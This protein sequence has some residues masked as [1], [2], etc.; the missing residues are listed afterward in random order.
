MS[1][2]LRQSRTGRRAVP[3]VVPNESAPAESTAP[4]APTRGRP[5]TGTVETVPLQDGSVSIRARFSHKGERY[6]VVFGRDVEGWT[7]Q[8]GH[9]ELKNIYAQLD[10]GIPVE[11]ILARY[12]PAP[13]PALSN[14]RPGVLFDLYASRWLERMRIG[15]IGDAP[16]AKNTHTDYLG[17]LSRYILPFFG[18]I[19][20]AQITDT[21]C[22]NFRAKLFRDRDKLSTII[23]AGGRPTDKDGRPRKP[24]SLRSIQMMMNLLAQILDDAVEDKLREDNPARSKR[25]R[26]RVPKP[27]RTFLEIDQLVAL[28][29]AAGELEA[30]P[31]STKRAKLTATQAQEIRARL[32]RGETQYALRLE[33]G[34]SSGAM[35]MLANGKTYRGDNGRVGWRALCAMLGYAGPRISEALDLKERDVRLHDPAASRLW[36]ADSKTETGIRH[37]EVTPMLRDILL[38]HRAEKIR[39]G[40]PTDPDAPFFCTRKGTRWDDGNVRERVLDAAAEL[41]SERL[42]ER[43]LPPLPHVTPHTMRRTYVSIMLLATKFDV[44]FVQ[45]QVG[46]SDSKL[47]VDVYQQLLDRSK[48]AHGAAFDALVSDAQAT[49]YGAQNGDFCPLFCPPDDFSLERDICPPPEFGLD[50]GETGDGRGW[51]RTTDLSRVKR[52]LSR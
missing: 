17:R 25:L 42:V 45:K 51:F 9:Q 3:S 21:D 19:P 39:R 33:Y 14:Y 37:V 4:K 8:R 29:D 2:E 27:D 5:K 34:M 26:V 6:R 50:T 49:L 16:L 15:E 30:A 24:L 38:A 52:A 41:A 12:E 47:T 1:A 13:L 18:R 11:Q 46:H 28:L 44:P 40:Y 48:R 43:G 22:K 7:E 32:A 35:S 36:I 23:E 31:R 10:A 20:V